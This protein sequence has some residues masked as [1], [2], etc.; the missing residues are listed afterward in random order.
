MYVEY[1]SYLFGAAS[2]QMSSIPGRCRVC[3]MV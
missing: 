2:D 1:M 3:G